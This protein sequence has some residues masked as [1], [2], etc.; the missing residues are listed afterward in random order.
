MATCHKLI[1]LKKKMMKKKTDGTEG[2]KRV[3]INPITQKT[4]NDAQ[5]YMK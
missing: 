5:K 3:K 1:T 2:L 4:Y